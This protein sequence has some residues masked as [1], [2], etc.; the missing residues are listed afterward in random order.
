MLRG[1]SSDTP[2]DAW[3]QWFARLPP[4]VADD[5]AGALAPMFPGGHLVVRGV[6]PSEGLAARL[7]ALARDVPSTAGLVLT[8]AALTDCIMA[9]RCDPA[10]WNDT[11]ALLDVLDASAQE[12]LGELP[13]VG[14]LVEHA[15]LR[16]PLWARQWKAQRDGWV[17][18]RTAVLAADR[19]MGWMRKTRLGALS[20]RPP[21]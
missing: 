1:M 21:T 15:R 18:L 14:E 2:L 17:Q 10:R 7:H 9:D 19:V 20:P 12:V 5:L 6:R 8:L 4:E 16:S 3:C 13:E 11:T